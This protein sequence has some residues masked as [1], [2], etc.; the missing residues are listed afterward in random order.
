MSAAQLDIFDWYHFEKVKPLR[1]VGTAT[2]EPAQFSEKC[3]PG[4]HWRVKIHW[5]KVGPYASSRDVGYATRAMSL[6]EARCIAF[7]YAQYCAEHTYGCPNARRL[8]S[9]R[10]KVRAEL[11]FESGEAI[12]IETTFDHR[13]LFFWRPPNQR[14]WE[15]GIPRHFF[16]QEGN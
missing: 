2:I 11:T 14:K 12:K 5:D 9:V 6:S 16:H 1:M 4:C 10:R 13:T 15:K 7:N 3:K 8:S